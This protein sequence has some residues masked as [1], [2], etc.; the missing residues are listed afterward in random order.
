MSRLLSDEISGAL[1]APGRED[2]NRRFGEHI[3]EC[4]KCREVVLDHANETVI[5]PLLRQLA[6]ERG[7]SFD[8]MLD[9][10][11]QEIRK[12]EQ[13]GQLK[14]KYGEKGC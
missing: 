14:S 10:F 6:S 8:K 13:A 4:P 1:A 3:K 11:V 7:V 9:E 5:L 2:D 12:K